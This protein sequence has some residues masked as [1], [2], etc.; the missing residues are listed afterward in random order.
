MRRCVSL[1]LFVLTVLIFLLSFRSIYPIKYKE[2][3]VE[4][5]ERYDIP[6]ELISSIINAESGFDKDSVSSVGAVGLMQVLPSTATEISNKFGY[7]EY[8]L[9]NPRTNIEFGCY[10]LRYLLNIYNQDVVYSLCAYNAGLNNVKYWDFKGDI[11]K[12]PVNQTKNYVKK[13]VKNIQVYKV[14]YY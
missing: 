2:I 11:E 10:Y 6:P 9:Y 8:D 12:I 7:S 5:S 4:Y 13:I 3:I 14:F 1:L